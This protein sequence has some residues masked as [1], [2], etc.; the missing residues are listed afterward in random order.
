MMQNKSHFVLVSQVRFPIPFPYLLGDYSRCYYS[1]W[2]DIL[3]GYLHLSGKSQT[4]S[5]T[6]QIQL[7]GVGH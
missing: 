2:G 4:E 6:E 3:L 1:N 7:F 5:Q